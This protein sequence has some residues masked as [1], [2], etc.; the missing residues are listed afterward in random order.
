MDSLSA[1][2]RRKARL[3]VST[4]AVVWPAYE[5]SYNAYGAGRSD[6]QVSLLESLSTTG[7]AFWSPE[8]YQCGEKVWIRFRIGTRTCQLR[9]IVRNNRPKTLRTRQGHVCGVEFLLC[10]Q[11]ALA[12]QIVAG[13][14]TPS[15]ASTQA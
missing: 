7:L 10:K 12:Q 15:V 5:A 6:L 13:Y 14:L 2:R 4:A 8:S 1:N 9:G 11:T 3:K